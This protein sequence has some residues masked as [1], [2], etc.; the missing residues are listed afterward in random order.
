VVQ[1]LVASLAPQG[2][3]MA[4]KAEENLRMYVELKTDLGALMRRR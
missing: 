4:N 2:D 3:D 1:I